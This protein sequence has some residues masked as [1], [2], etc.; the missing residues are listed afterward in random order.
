MCN[1]LKKR[2][3]KKSAQPSEPPGCPDA[4]ALVMRTIS[5]RIWVAS[6]CS[7]VT[8]S[9]QKYKYV[10]KIAANIVIVC[11]KT[12]K[13]QKLQQLYEKVTPAAVGSAKDVN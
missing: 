12:G 4:A 6:S 5:R 8:E 10:N 3:L 7:S 2:A 9:I 1:T 11:L 13:L